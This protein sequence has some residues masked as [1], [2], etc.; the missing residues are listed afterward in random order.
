MAEDLK[1]QIA[2]LEQQLA[3][4]QG[5]N[6]QQLQGLLGGGYSS[7][8][9][10]MKPEQIQQIYGLLAGGAEDP[11]RVGDQYVRA[12]QSNQQLAQFGQKPSNIREWE[13]YNS[14]T[15]TDKKA[16]LEMK[17][18]VSMK[19]IAGSL[20]GVYSSGLRDTAPVGE[21]GDVYSTRAEEA[22]TAEIMASSGALGTGM[23]ARY[24]VLGEGQTQRMQGYSEARRLRMQ[25]G[26]GELNPGQYK[27]LLH[28]VWNN[29]DMEALNALAER[30]ARARLKANGEVR[31]TDADVEGEKKALFGAGRTEEFT[32]A[33]LDRLISEIERQEQ[34]Y[35]SLGGYLQAPMHGTRQDPGIAVPGSGTRV[36]PQGERSEDQIL[37]EYGVN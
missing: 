29:A 20:Q 25:L 33:S 19:E 34:E 12:M 32:G 27:Q 14:L 18:G 1:S 10:H 8:Q 23:A 31:P 37:S 28:L 35:N 11:A 24:Q 9:Q 4:M 21:G 36:Q 7:T 5:G 15:D 3:S 30:T 13:Y 26:E 2:G 17:R 6:Q 16:Y 22:K